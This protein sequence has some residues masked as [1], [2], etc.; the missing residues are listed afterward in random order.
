MDPEQSP[1][2]ESLG[3][4][5]LA[6]EKYAEAE[7][8][9]REDLRRNANNGRSQFGL[10]QA[11]RKQNKDADARSVESDLKDSWKHAEGPIGDGTVICCTRPER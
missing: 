4:A 3:Q 10:V 6:G 5:L 8:V 7:T 11:L 2:R 1:I 9:F